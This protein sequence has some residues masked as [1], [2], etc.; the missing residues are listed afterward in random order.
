MSEDPIQIEAAGEVAIVRLC[1]GTTNPLSA[2]LVAGLADAIQT[3][4]ADSTLRGLVLTSRN[5]KFFSIGFDIPHL[6]GLSQADFATFFRA[7]NLMCLDLYTLPKPT[8]AAIS[9]HATAGGCILALCC[10]YRLIVEGRTL[11]GLNEIKLGVP[12]PYAAD[13]ILRE[14]IGSRKAR[15]V[16]ESGDF[17]SPDSAVELG[18]VDEVVPGQELVRRATERVRAL[19]SMPGGAFAQIKRSR[20]EVVDRQIRS[21]FDET[22]RAFVECWYSQP[23]R[24]RL[25]EALGKFQY[26]S[27]AKAS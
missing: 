27:R 11:I 5:D 22:D 20:T 26:A 19:G 2:A 3:I 23:A 9:G 7:F 1:L 14:T 15:R 24:E 8:A 25:T 13:R 18:L 16:V 21:Q 4:G 17:Y 6:I 12:V 10:D